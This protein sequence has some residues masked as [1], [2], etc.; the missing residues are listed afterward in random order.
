MA[1]EKEVKISEVLSKVPNRFILSIATA[2]RARQIVEGAK[3]LIEVAENEI[4][5]PILTSLEEI[6]Q[7]KI[8]VLIE[9]DRDEELELIEEVERYF[10]KKEPVVIEDDSSKKTKKDK[11]KESKSKSKTKSLA[12]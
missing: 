6:R 12:A 2:R 10:D 5:H 4:P 11:D 3:P 7:D 8:T 1:N 9:Q